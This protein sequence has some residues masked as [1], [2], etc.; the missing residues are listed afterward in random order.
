LEEDDKLSR[1]KTLNDK[2]FRTI[3]LSREFCLNTKVLII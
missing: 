3:K 2:R 1:Q